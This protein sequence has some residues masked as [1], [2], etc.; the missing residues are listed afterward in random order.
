MTASPFPACQFGPP[1]GSQPVPSDRLRLLWRIGVLTPGPVRA[2][3]THPGGSSTA[4]DVVA[5]RF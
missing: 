1:A 4:P 5:S 3:H 2:D